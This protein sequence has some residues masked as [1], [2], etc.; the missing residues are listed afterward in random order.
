MTT[1][2]ERA[3]IRGIGDY[4]RPVRIRPALAIAPTVSHDDFV[5]I[6]LLAIPGSHPC[7]AVAAMLDVKGVGYDRVDLFPGLS[8]GWL[9]LTGFGAG[10]V[11]AMRMDGVHVQGS[12]EI[13]RAL[14]VSWPDPRLYPADAKA[15]ARV[16]EIETWADGPLQDV[17]RRID[18]W[19]LLRSRAGVQAAL[20]GARLQFRVPNG[21]AASVAWPILR[22]DAALNGASTDAAQSDLAALPAMLD[23]VDAW[24]ADGSLGASDPTAADFQIAGSLRLLL[25]LEDLASLFA[26]RPAARLAR[27]LIPVFPGSIPAGVL[28]AAWLP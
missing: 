12:R 2:V 5:S 18:L 26:D 15:R 10:T 8:R 27:G 17:A 14:D 28:P 3:R 20:T 25:G 19:A 9:R 21:L 24:I 13:A 11:P 1:K 23:R 4:P 22:F 6:R 7:A 16:E